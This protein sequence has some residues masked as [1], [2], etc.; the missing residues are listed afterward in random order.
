MIYN[1]NLDKSTSMRRSISAL[2]KDLKRWEDDRS[3]Q[4]KTVVEDVVAHEV[5]FA[6]SSSQRFWD[7]SS[8][9]IRNV[10]K[11]NLLN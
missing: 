8:R 11:M 7:H 9:N 3:K 6:F 5:R 10:T 1:A 2:R 4:K